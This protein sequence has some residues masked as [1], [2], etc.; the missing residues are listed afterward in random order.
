MLIAALYMMFLCYIVLLE[1]VV[2]LA[3]TNMSTV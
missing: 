3:A 1:M 2:V